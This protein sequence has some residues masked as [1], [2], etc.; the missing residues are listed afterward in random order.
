MT[1]LLFY[2]LLWLFSCFICLRIVVQSNCYLFY[3]VFHRIL[4]FLY[5]YSLKCSFEKRRETFDSKRRWRRFLPVRLFGLA[6]TSVSLLCRCRSRLAD[7]HM[8]CQM[9]SHSVT[10]CPHDNY[11]GCLMSYVGLIGTSFWGSGN[12]KKSESRIL[13]QLHL[14]TTVWADQAASCGHAADVINSVLIYTV[15]LTRTCQT[16]GRRSN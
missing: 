12:E 2:S 4:Y 1:V 15:M 14:H 8:N 7:F 10:T 9:T 16:Q 5:F 13:L 11:N 6:L 3:L